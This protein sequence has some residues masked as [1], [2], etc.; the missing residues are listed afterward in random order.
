MSAISTR[1]E[2]GNARGASKIC[3]AYQPAKGKQATFKRILQHYA[4]LVICPRIERHESAAQLNARRLAAAQEVIR[5]APNYALDICQMA[6]SAPRELPFNF[7]ALD[8]FRMAVD[9]QHRQRMG[10]KH[11]CT[12]R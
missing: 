2:A 9:V 1:Q 7:T 8:A 6:G 5:T 10:V 4:N 3:Q 11:E 12:A